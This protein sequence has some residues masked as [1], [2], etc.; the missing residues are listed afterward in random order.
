MDTTQKAE[1]L[2][3]FRVMSQYWQ[4]RHVARL[5]ES[6]KMGQQ[7]IKKTLPIYDKALRTLN[8]QI[9]ELYTRYSTEAGLDVLELTRVLSGVD[10]NKFIRNMHQTLK[11]LGLGVGDIYNKQF[12]Q[13]LTGLEAMKQQ[14]Y[15]EIEKL[16][17]DI[18]PIQTSAYKDIIKQSYGETGQDIRRLAGDKSAPFQTITTQVLGEM[19]RERWAGGNYSHRIWG[20]TSRLGANLMD[21][22]GSGLIVGV[23]QQ[24][25][26]NEIGQRFDASQYELMRLVRTEANYFNNQAELQS[27]KDEGIEY[28]R[29]DAVIDGRTSQWCDPAQGGLGGMIF[30]VGDA[31]VGLNYPPLHP[32]CRSTTYPIYP[33]EVGKEKVWSS[34]EVLNGQHIEVA[35]T[36]PPQVVQTKTPVVPV[37][38]KF[39]GLKGIDEFG[40]FKEYFRGLQP[41]GK[42][43]REQVEVY[44]SQVVNGQTKSVFVDRNNINKVVSDNN[45]LVAFQELK[46][47]P[48]TI[49]VDRK[50]YAKQVKGD[51]F[52]KWVAKMLKE[53]E[54][55]NMRGQW[56]NISVE[57][58]KMD[59]KGYD[60][61]IVEVARDILPK[62]VYNKVMKG[63]DLRHTLGQEWY[64]KGDY[65]KNTAL[66]SL[67]RV[68]KARN[69]FDK[70]IDKDTANLNAYMELLTSDGTRDKVLFAEP[71]PKSYWHFNRNTDLNVVNKILREGFDKEKAGGISEMQFNK[72][73]KMY[74]GAMEKSK[75]MYDLK[76][77]R[78]VSFN[79][80]FTMKD[81]FKVGSTFADK[82]FLFVSQDKVLA[83]QYMR[84]KD[85]ALL[86]IFVPKGAR[87][88]GVGQFYDAHNQMILDRK[89]QYKVLRII[90]GDEYPV[91]QLQA[92]PQ[93]LIEKKMDMDYTGKLKDVVIRDVAGKSIEVVG[94]D[95]QVQKLW[96]RQQLNIENTPLSE[97]TRGTFSASDRKIQIQSEVLRKGVTEGVEF[98]SDAEFYKGFTKMPKEIQE[99]YL[100]KIPT[101][102][103]QRTLYH[104]TGHAIDYGKVDFAKRVHITSDET[105]EILLKGKTTDGTEFMNMFERLRDT[106]IRQIAFERVKSALQ[107][108]E[109]DAV[110]EEKQIKKM[111]SD[112]TIMKWMTDNTEIRP[113]RNDG[114]NPPMRLSTDW[115]DGYVYDR[116][117]IF[118]DAFAWYMQD[119]KGMEKKVPEMYNY[120]GKIWQKEIT[121]NKKSEKTLSK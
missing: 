29:Y 54:A 32:H 89:T 12:L 55:F 33:D 105:G 34:A 82:S 42:L 13:K 45:L 121:K 120:I 20:N 27:Y 112:S 64:Q 41:M 4:G 118:A 51:D 111:P 88:L 46:K 67:T 14:V 22:L 84:E 109:R 104:E 52:D 57:M 35:P 114:T 15:W 9:N 56:K 53:K 79:E 19:L 47:L 93:S 85:T 107:F 113:M 25:M 78:G 61:I 95:E 37:E 86:E 66:G 7:A 16:A 99:R 40:S 23:S 106:E 28:Y 77:Y 31:Q 63:E 73:V 17:K 38:E 92:I 74:D 115:V 24:K 100:Y 59:I 91:I 10:R 2:A 21:T 110:L 11:S 3:E 43:N 36:P 103:L 87:A 101:Y 69:M 26:A 49:A 58:P 119:P 5:V 81:N 83:E 50:E 72:I 18:E 116:S 80:K 90:E 44:K 102:E 68:V 75:L 39:G 94:I 6:E 8:K 96:E 1:W 98:W 60:D 65:D 97:N 76:L 71:L 48:R 117:E 108:N 70:Q 30:K 62:D